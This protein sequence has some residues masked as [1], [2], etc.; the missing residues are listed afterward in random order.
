MYSVLF[1]MDKSGSMKSLGTEPI[2]SLNNFYEKQI[3]SG[4]FNSTLIFFNDKV[5]FV[6][7]N[8]LCSKL[9]K[10]KEDEYKPNG[11]TSLYDAIGEGIEYQKKVQNE[12]VIVVILTDGLENASQKY[13]KNKIK[14]LI[15]ELENNG[16]K[17]I[18]LGAN[19]D[20]FEVGKSIGVNTSSNY[21]YSPIGLNCIMKTVS[22]NISCCLSNNTPVKDINLDDKQKDLQIS[23]DSLTNERTVIIKEK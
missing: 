7:K 13:N 15:S 8:I 23:V 14:Q 19:Q 10:I 21:E 22:E 5:E 11:M 2:D 9:D 17:F 6:H 20:A 3:E 18:Y 16:W 1:I 12:N 4:N